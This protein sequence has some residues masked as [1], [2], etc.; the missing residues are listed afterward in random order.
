MIAQF[1]RTAIDGIGKKRLSRI[2]LAWT[3]THADAETG[4]RY[5]EG[6]LPADDIDARL[7]LIDEIEAQRQA[8]RGWS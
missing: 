2:G 7:G 3:A 5:D 6:R 4:R 1:A 8:Y